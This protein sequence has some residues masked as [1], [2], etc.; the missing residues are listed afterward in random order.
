MKKAIY[1]ILLVTTFAHGGGGASR[2]KMPDDGEDVPRAREVVAGR[3]EIVKLVEAAV[4]NNSGF[5][6]LLKKDNVRF[7]CKE[8]SAHDQLCVCAGLY[9]LNA[10]QLVERS[11]YK[12]PRLYLFSVDFDESTHSRDDGVRVDETMYA[13]SRASL[14]V[15]SKINE[16]SRKYASVFEREKQ[17]LLQRAQ[18][19]LDMQKRIK[20]V[21]RV[22]VVS[23]NC[24]CKDPRRHRSCVESMLSAT[25]HQQE[26]NC[27]S[28][29]DFVLEGSL[30]EIVFRRDSPNGT[31]AICNKKLWKD[32]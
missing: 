2:Y 24:N 9:K 10:R 19:L 14:Y 4:F 12:N 29:G 5:Q 15:P 17:A 20:N 3:S 7:N 1:N 18:A 31:C 25:S 23:L 27:L 11:I 16:I 21:L 22:A 26:R 28:C 6:S 13:L 32:R 8:S 30:H